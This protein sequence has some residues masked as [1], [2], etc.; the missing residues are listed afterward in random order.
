M[1]EESGF[2]HIK[3]GPAVDTFD[4]AVGEKSAR[5]FDV[6]AHAFMATKPT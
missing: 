1:L 2:E 4:G 5:A 3:I 6:Y